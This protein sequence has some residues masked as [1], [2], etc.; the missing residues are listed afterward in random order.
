MTGI[1]IKLNLLRAYSSR[2]AYAILF[3][4]LWCLPMLVS[5]QTTPQFM[6]DQCSACHDLTGP[7]PDTL[8][9]LWSR[10]GPD[11]FY[12]GNKYRREWLVQWLQA[13]QRI[14][15][16]GMFY[17][18]HVKASPD[19]DVIDKASLTAHPAL[20]AE[21]ATAVT[22]YLMTLVPMAALITAGDYQP[23]K[24]SPAM[25][26]MMFDKF[27]GC[28]ACHEIEPGYGGA[29]GPE[30]YTVAKRLQAD[31]LISFMRKPQAWDPRTF[32]PDKALKEQDLQKLVHYFRA[33]S[34]MTF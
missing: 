34:E 13:P 20:A 25:G 3:V 12:A 1:A 8:A 6:Q 21:Q 18:N 32:M 29:S 17:V 9:G 22:E 4:G 16:A 28:L 7:A 30:I 27:R 2:S 26:E 33:L 19:G 31:Y 5:A 23:G 10:K 24:I 14:R 15:P 11:L